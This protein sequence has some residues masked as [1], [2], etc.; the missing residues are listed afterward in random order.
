MRLIGL[1]CWLVVGYAGKNVV[2]EGEKED[3]T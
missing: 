3:L 2:L 1:F